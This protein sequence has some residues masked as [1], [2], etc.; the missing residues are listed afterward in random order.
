MRAFVFIFTLCLDILLYR[1]DISSFNEF[2]NQNFNGGVRGYQIMKHILFTR[3]NIQ[4]YKY[5]PL[6]NWVKSLNGK[7]VLLRERHKPWYIRY[8]TEISHVATRPSFP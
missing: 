1:V 8:I 2:S 4:Q 5:E 6:K 7:G 3:G